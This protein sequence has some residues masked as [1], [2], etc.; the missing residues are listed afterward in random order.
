ME[1]EHLK[2]L[3]DDLIHSRGRIWTDVELANETGLPLAEVQSAITR[4]IAAGRAIS[5]GQSIHRVLPRDGD[6]HA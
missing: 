5:P 1:P 6:L 4:L 3:I 2:H